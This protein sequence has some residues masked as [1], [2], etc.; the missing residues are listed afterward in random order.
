MIHQTA[1]NL[2]RESY[3]YFGFDV[4]PKN[5]GDALK[6]MQALGIAGLNVTLPHKEA[7]IEFLDE[8]AADA[9][10][11]GAV[12]TVYV[13]NDMLVG[14][15]TDVDGVVA[16]LK[17][18]RDQISNE[19]V[20]VFGAGGGARAV[21]YSLISYFRPAEICVI[22]RDASRG[23]LLRKFFS[24]SQNYRNIKVFELH[25]IDEGKAV[26]SSKLVVNA[27]Q[28]G[29]YPL[30]N[31]NIMVPDDREYD[32]K[33]FFDLVYNPVQ[34]NFLKSAKKKNAITVSGLEMLYQQA[35][36][37][38]EL[39]TGVVMPLDRVRAKLDAKFQGEASPKKRRAAV[40]K[41]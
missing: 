36:K 28:V 2:A 27:T 29:M 13:R 37:A 3:S 22:N 31:E 38:F 7:V 21:V 20:T 6:G 10:L 8:V 34:T 30:V 32:G 25:N 12:N 41:V 24:D 5:L 35:A 16:A 39:W 26:E 40:Q 19:S 23:E 11:V 17:P 1:F 15:N 18:F 33:I 4:L 9:R 14:H